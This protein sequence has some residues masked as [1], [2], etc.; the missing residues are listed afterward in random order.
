MDPRGKKKKK[1][2]ADSTGK[3]GTVTVRHA[4]GDE[5][6]INRCDLAAWKRKKY[7]LVEA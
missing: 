4:N 1:S 5:K 2:A 6:T 3:G 7:Y